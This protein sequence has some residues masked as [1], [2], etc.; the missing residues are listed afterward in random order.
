MMMIDF[1]TDILEQFTGTLS[2]ERGDNREM[3]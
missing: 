1:E 2:L 3:R